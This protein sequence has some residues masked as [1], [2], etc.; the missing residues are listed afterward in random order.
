MKNDMGLSQRIPPDYELAGR[1]LINLKGWGLVWLLAGCAILFGLS[2]ILG[3]T[4]RGLLRGYSEG[5]VNLDGW[6]FLIVLGVFVAFIIL[7]E[8]VHGLVFLVF[9]GKPRFGVKLVRRFFPVA[10]YASAT[11]HLLSRNHYLL[12]G[13]APFLA[14]TPVFLVIGILAN[15][16]G[17][18]ALAIIAMAMSVSGS[19]G[20]LMMVWKIRR[21]GRKTLYEDTENG[22]NWYV[23]SAESQN[24]GSS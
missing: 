5:S 23:P 9:G 3:L 15:A 2:F 24:H 11:G 12:V 6:V 17:I 16:E 20:D 10:F 21:H 4:I 1:W 13:L 8:G 14:L 22:F 7:H 18:V 19:I